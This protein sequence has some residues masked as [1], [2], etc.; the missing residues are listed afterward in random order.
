MQFEWDPGKAK[1]NFRKHGVT[2]EEAQSVFRDPLA[3]PF[4]DPDHS[5]DEERFLVV[6]ESVSRRLLIVSFTDRSSAVRIISARLA[7]QSE[8]RSY[9]G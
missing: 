2:F 1:S 6:G 3:T 8:R 5:D 4:Y 9:E 7:T